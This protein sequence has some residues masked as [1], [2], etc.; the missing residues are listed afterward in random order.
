MKQNTRSFSNNVNLAHYQ[1]KQK[2]VDSYKEKQS[3]T[4]DSKEE[5]QET[6]REVECLSVSST[7]APGTFAIRRVTLHKDELPGGSLFNKPC[8]T[9][10]VML[11]K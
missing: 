5:Q 2:K 4:S 9:P 7:S 11:H 1:P 6:K 10:N 8:F 3:P